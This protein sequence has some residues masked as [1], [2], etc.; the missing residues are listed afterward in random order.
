MTTNTYY[1]RMS[2]GA[3][4]L[5]INSEINDFGYQFTDKISKFRMQRVSIIFMIAAYILLPTD[6]VCMY[7]EW[8]YP[9]YIFARFRNK[10]VKNHIVSYMI[11]C[12]HMNAVF[13]IASYFSTLVYHVQFVVLLYFVYSFVSSNKHSNTLSILSRAILSVDCKIA[14]SVSAISSDINLAIFGPTAVKKK[15]KSC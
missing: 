15:K 13:F 2:D 10:F 4:S 9:A 8:V 11:V 5:Y 14:G 6:L 3:Y 7:L 1:W 12:S